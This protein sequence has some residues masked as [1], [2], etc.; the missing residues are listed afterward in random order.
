M[1]TRHYF[2]WLSLA[3]S[4]SSGLALLAEPVVLDRHDEAWQVASFIEDSGLASQTIFG[5][6][7]APDGTAWLGTTKGLYRYDGYEWK[8][9]TNGLPSLCVRAVF[10]SRKGELWVGTDQGAGVYDGRKFDDRGF[11][12]L[13]TG[14]SIRRM[15]EDPDGTLWFCAD[16]WPNAPQA[17]GLSCW[18]DGRWKTYGAAQGVAG[19]QVFNYFRDALGRQFALTSLGIVRMQ[20]E[21]WIA[22]AEPGYPEDTP[23]WMMAQLPRGDLFIQSAAG[24]WNLVDG[25]WNLAE[26]YASTLCVTREGDLI[27]C[28]LDNNRRRFC[29]TLWNGS[30]FVPASAQIHMPPNWDMRMIRQAPD[31]TIWGVGQGILVRW[32][33]RSRVWRHYGNLPPPQLVDAQNRIW[34]ADT[35]CYVQSEEGF[36]KLDRIRGPLYPDGKGSFWAFSDDRLVRI[37]QEGT[38]SPVEIPLPLS[39]I[40][41][42]VA[43]GQGN[44]WFYGTDPLGARAG[45]MLYSGGTWKHFVSPQFTARRILSVS[46]D[47]VEGIWVVAVPPETNNYALIRVQK[48]Q[49]RRLDLGPDKPPLNEPR[50]CVDRQG[51]WLYGA[52]GLWHALPT[53]LHSWKQLDT[54]SHSGFYQHH[55]DFTNTLFFFS[56]GLG[57]DDNPGVAIYCDGQW[58]QFFT[59]FVGLVQ[60]TGHDTLLLGGDDRFYLWNA[61]RKDHLG[62]IQIPPDHSLVSVLCDANRGY[63][64]GTDDGV[65][66]ARPQTDPPRIRIHIADP[67]RELSVNGLLQARV[68]AIGKFTPLRRS[69]LQQFS[70]R[71]DGHAWSF[72]GPLP[73]DGFPTSGLEPG[74]THTLEVRACDTL[75]DVFPETAQATFYLLPRP[76]QSTP[77]FRIL[78]A[79]GLLLIGLLSWTSIKRTRQ[80]ARSNSTLREE[81]A[82]RQKIEGE[83]RRIRDE[84]EERVRE[85]TDE[86]TRSTLSLKQQIS[87]RARLEQELRYSQKMEAIG[88]LAGGMA[89]DFNNL[90]TVIRGHTEMLLT[91]KPDS[92]RRTEW[93][94]EI[95]LASERAAD[96]TNQLLAFSRRQVLQIQVLDLNSVISD[97]TQFL[98]R[99]LGEQVAIQLQMSPHPVVVEADRNLLEQVLVNLAVNA[100]DAM[101][102][103][104]TLTVATRVSQISPE[105]LAQRPEA[106]AG[107]FACLRVSDTGAGMDEATRSRI[108]EPFFT[109]KGPGVS[110]GLGLATVY[111]IVKQHSGWIEV[112]SQ[113]GHGSVFVIFL[114]T[115]DKPVDRPPV[116]QTPQPLQGGNETILVVED[117]VSV[118]SFVS[119]CLRHFGYQ[120][121]QAASGPEALEIWRVHR[122]RIDLVLTDVVMPEGMSGKQ[123]AERLRADSPDV[124]V[125]YTSGYNLEAG[126]PDL[127]LEE[128]CWYLPKPF[129]RDGL[130]RIIRDCLNAPPPV[131]AQT[132]TRRD[133]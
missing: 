99:L 91:A 77:W 38:R 35:N 116:S 129:N 61:S 31:G 121:L 6:E 83:L 29:F 55:T 30:R 24:L 132:Q 106:R 21:R 85:R 120:T 65:M 89:H 87:E 10:L 84:L 74:Q 92:D 47:P 71:F 70:W 32:E 12:Q 73:L 130:L 104:G 112:E 103:G 97:V 68:E 72:F 67:T 14:H 76:I 88:Q 57:S 44:S 90:F 53:N 19:G 49:V 58:Q 110:T 100:R 75:G 127:K 34:F 16:R 102:Q 40:E 50:L 114:P 27:S 101:P 109:T 20:G 33:Y 80:I 111:G 11:G 66:Y 46:P 37:T 48:D 122:N 41:G 2:R 25:R 59:N 108:F 119:N 79:L 125:I 17:G 86:L 52:N 126:D 123:L 69:T 64:V 18:K 23:A 93:L 22:L 118:R 124:R 9:L 78:M 62:V 39:R 26:P 4:F 36:T 1:N 113:P 96:L 60:E 63:W 51:L 54:L 105:A 8:P 98:L 3:A 42:H 95:E 133:K 107:S 13:V 131:S 7:F 82:Q 117:E 128:A 43:D 28:Q 5:I 56:G 45:L 15:V 81:V 115:S 94:M